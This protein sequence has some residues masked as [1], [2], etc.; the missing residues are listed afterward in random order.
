MIRQQRRHPVNPAC[1]MRAFEKL[2]GWSLENAGIEVRRAV[3]V[4]RTKWT[5]CYKV[6]VIPSRQPQ[7]KASITL[8]PPAG[9]KLASRRSAGWRADLLEIG[10]YKRAGRE[11]RRHGYRGR[12][13]WSPWGRFGDFWKAL[14]DVDALAAE[15]HVLDHLRQE[16]FL[17]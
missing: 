14:R 15:V 3:S 17:E 7:Y 5:I 2:D 10:W 9:R 8:W 6:H 13:Q 1:L 16:P 4:G 12:W 11:L